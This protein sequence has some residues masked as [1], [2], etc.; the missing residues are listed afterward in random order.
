MY[1][2]HTWCWDD[3]PQQSLK[4]DEQCPPHWPLQVNTTHQSH[5]IL[6]ISSSN[7]AGYEAFVCFGWSSGHWCHEPQ[8]FSSK[9]LLDLQMPPDQQQKNINNSYKFCLMTVYESDLG[10]HR[11]FMNWFTRGAKPKEPQVE[12]STVEI[13]QRFFL[14][15]VYLFLNEAHPISL[16]HIPTDIITNS[17]F[18][19]RHI[20]S[21]TDVCVK[22][23]KCS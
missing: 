22:E 11:W 18:H 3:R 8:W 9:V 4:Y 10:H 14:R 19:K 23:R 13:M 7:W 16:T 15:K 17:N 20:I 5:E 12:N 2:S 1:I 21:K 6:L